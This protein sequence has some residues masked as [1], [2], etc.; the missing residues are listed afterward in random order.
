MTK[1]KTILTWHIHGNYL[2]YLTHTPHTFILPVKPGRPEGYCG[3]T[4][5]FD[6]GPNV[7][8]VPADEVKNLDLD[9]IVYQSEKNFTH[10][11]HEILSED[12]RLLPRYYIEHNPP[13]IHPTNTRHPGTADPQVT[14]V[15]VTSYNRLM[16]DNGD[17]PTVVIEHG[18]TTPR[19]ISY[20][21]ELPRGVVIINNISDRGRRLG[22]DV[23]Q[24][25]RAEVPLDIIGMNANKVGGLGEVPYRKLPMFI[26][27]YRFLFT[28]I[29]YSSLGLSICEAMMV[30]LPVIGLATTELGT[31]IKNGRTGYVHT[32]V[33]T[34][35]KRMRQLLVMPEKARRMSRF[36][37][38]Y[39]RRRF[40]IERFARNWAT[41]LESGSLD[42]RLT[43]EDRSYLA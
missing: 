29:R 26:S 9:A 6:W 8:E 28:P 23:F 12:Q 7:I 20:T 18:V 41:L 16:W 31:I 25:A 30:G 3:K 42:H 36:A 14:I 38:Q 34:L 19:G 37:R 32:N 22:L 24:T 17:N 13:Q 15:H 33:G 21:G 39:A 1:Q 43:R 27:R 4:A 10:D 2:Y 11:Q 35:I 5:N 40:G